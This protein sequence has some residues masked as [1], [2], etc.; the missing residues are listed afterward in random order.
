[1]KFRLCIVSAV[2]LMLSGCIVFTEGSYLGAYKAYNKGDYNDAIAKVDS[3][4][5]R[6]MD[7]YSEFQRSDL[8]LLKAKSLMKL[9][10][11]AQANALFKYVANT[12]SASES[13]YIAKSMITDSK[14]SVITNHQVVVLGDTS[15]NFAAKECRIAAR[16][17]ALEYFGVSVKS[18][19]NLNQNGR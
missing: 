18:E 8:Y 3:S 19:T 1:M 17:K 6:Y 4:L 9:G 7:Q 5:S 12:F 16:Q 11:T 13:G 10:E 15:V 14:N 2:C